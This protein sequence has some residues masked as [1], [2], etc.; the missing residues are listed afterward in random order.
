MKNGFIAIM[1]IFLFS[2][3]S[4][5]VLAEDKVLGPVTIMNTDRIIQFPETVTTVSFSAVNEDVSRRHTISMDLDTI[6]WLTWGETSTLLFLADGAQS[7]YRINVEWACIA[8]GET[9]TE[10]ILVQVRPDGD[11]RL[12]ADDSILISGTKPSNIVQNKL[13]VKRDGM[14]FANLTLQQIAPVTGTSMKSR[15]DSDFYF[16]R[17]AVVRIVADFPLPTPCGCPQP[18]FH[19]YTG[20]FTRINDVT[21]EVLLD[22][23][24]EI[25]AFY[26]DPNAATATPTPL[27]TAAPALRGDANGS[28]SIDIV[29]ALVVAQFYVGFPVT[30]DAAMTDTNCNG[31]VDIVDA[32]LIAQ[33]YVGIIQSFCP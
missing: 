25:T 5:T 27:P 14:P 16:D 12:E 20:D 8:P 21:A 15:Y 9:K 22:I 2:C 23:D 3:I 1:A 30:V 17:G 24:K 26:V 4:H 13:S 28:G 29:D 7:D 33:Y 6:G 11:S 19:G 31:S 18:E 32:L 10:T